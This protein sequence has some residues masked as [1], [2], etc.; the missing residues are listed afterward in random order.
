M[1]Y[2]VYQFK[3]GERLFYVA[4]VGIGIIVITYL[5]YKSLLISL[6]CL[7]LGIK[8][9]D[10]IKKACIKKRK[11][12]L[13]LEFREFLYSL[14]VCLSS[15]FSIDNALPHTVEELSLLYPNGAL[16]I[17]E[18]QL[19]NRRIKLGETID[20]AFSQFSQ[21]IDSTTISIF[22]ASLKVG[23]EQGGNLVEVLRDNSNMIIDQLSTEQ[24]IEVITAEKQLEVRFLSC[25]PIMLIAMLN[26]SSP[27]FMSVIYTT[28][29]GRIGM[30]IAMIIIGI[31][32]LIAR[33]LVK[34]HT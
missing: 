5:M 21:R 30:T 16:I 3:A 11:R 25:F 17:D 10:Q 1:D 34:K 33:D 2:N 19:I 23:M 20:V 6:L 31:G 8:V 28:V 15:G 29:I 4:V 18:I 9:M 32:I 24:E 26:Y 12:Q 13:L 7:P 14:T 27:D 22:V